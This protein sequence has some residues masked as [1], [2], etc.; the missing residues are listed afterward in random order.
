MNQRLWIYFAIILMIVMVIIS[1]EYFNP[2]ILKS[3]I[4]SI[5]VNILI[6]LFIIALLIERSLEVFVITFRN[7]QYIK[8]TDDIARYI[9]I[10]SHAENAELNM[11]ELCDKRTKLAG[12]KNKTQ[13]LTILYGLVLGIIVSLI[14]FRVLDPFVDSEAMKAASVS[15]TDL[16]RKILAFIDVLLTGFL[17]GG[18]AD[19]LHKLISVI[20]GFLSVSRQQINRPVTPAGFQPSPSNPQ[21]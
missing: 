2:I 1:I 11:E 16:Q 21:L 7:D 8:L 19:G 9:E 4:P 6:S 18:G 17:I 14:G 12:Y 10:K 3:N 20:T 5:A 13:Q 15:L